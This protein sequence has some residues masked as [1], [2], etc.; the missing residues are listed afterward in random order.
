MI[1]TIITLEPGGDKS[2][3][4]TLAE[5]TVINLASNAGRITSDYAW[6]IRSDSGGKRFVAHGCLVDSYNGN[7]VDLLWEVLAEWKSG[8]ECP[9][10]NHGHPVRLIKDH[11]AYWKEADPT[12]DPC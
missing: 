1:R 4:K 3:S 6:R 7:V 10:D 12:P 9:I 5:I 8:R 2:R 11:K